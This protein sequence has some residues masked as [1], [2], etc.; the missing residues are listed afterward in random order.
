M[1]YLCRTMGNGGIKDSGLNVYVQ[2]EVSSVEAQV[3]EPHLIQN[4]AYFKNLSFEQSFD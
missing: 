3:E 4:F 2:L 1:Y